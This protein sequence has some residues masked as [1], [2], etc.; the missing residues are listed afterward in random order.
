MWSPQ[1]LPM[2]YENISSV[3]S[4]L[5]LLIWHPLHKQS[6]GQ[7]F[8]HNLHKQ[9]CHSNLLAYENGGVFTH[10]SR[11]LSMRLPIKKCGLP[12]IKSQRSTWNVHTGREKNVDRG[13]RYP[14]AKNSSP[15]ITRRLNCC[16][17]IIVILAKPSLEAMWYI[18]GFTNIVYW[19]SWAPW[20]YI[21]IYV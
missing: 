13:S 2:W 17:L 3:L 18:R 10:E 8:T 11:T 9:T 1:A 4:C 5:M 6:N 20:A 15:I 19:S 16:K 14:K 12:S 7:E 21:Y